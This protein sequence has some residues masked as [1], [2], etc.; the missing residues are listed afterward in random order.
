MPIPALEHRQLAHPS[1]VP[2]RARKPRF[3]LPALLLSSLSLALLLTACADL[4]EVAKFA[5]SAKAASTGYSDIVNDFSGSEK[6]R[7]LYARDA[8]KP[9]IQADIDARDSETPDMLSAQKPLV[10]YIA[11]LAAI[12]TDTPAS[13]SA[14][15]SAS[16]VKGAS[17]PASAG[18]AKPSASVSAA[19]PSSASM[20]K[21]GMTSAQATAGMTLTSSIAKAVTA[22]Y[23]SDK[24][25]KAI[26]DCNQD[27]QD[28]LK[29]LEQ[30][31]GTDYPLTLENETLQV[32]QYYSDKTAEY[33]DKEPLAVLLL[34]IQKKQDLDAIAKRKQAAAAYTKILT[35]IGDGHQK[36][37]DA[38]E[39]ISASQLISIVEPFVSDIATQSI[40]VAQAF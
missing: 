17:G 22:G 31:V 10:D 1:V 2:A 14:G 38:G 4:T 34:Q 13:A 5:A 16:G 33:Q 23:R 7:L 36:L 37:Y 39:K 35:D 20:Q 18:A 21:A 28:Y 40:K 11:A 24:T 19:T 9:K 3:F 26:H 32:N 15:S 30:I 29:G 6:R 12:S 25:G 8:D 27:L